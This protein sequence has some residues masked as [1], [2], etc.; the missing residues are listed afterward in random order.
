[1]PRSTPLHD[2]LEVVQ[3]LFEVV[4][5]VLEHGPDHVLDEVPGVDDAV[6]VVI[7]VNPGGGVSSGSDGGL[8]A[9]LVAQIV[10]MSA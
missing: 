2:V 3:D 8:S 5:I 7:G 4:G 6:A 1:M 10:T 9:G